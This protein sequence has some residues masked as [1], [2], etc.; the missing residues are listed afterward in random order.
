MSNEI[1]M[2][3]GMF[4]NGLILVGMAMTAQQFSKPVKEQRKTKR[5]TVEQR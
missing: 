3:T 5:D 1:F 4:C 2:M